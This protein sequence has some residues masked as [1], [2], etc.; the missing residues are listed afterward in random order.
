MLYIH[1]LK[2]EFRNMKPMMIICE[3]KKHCALC[4]KKAHLNSQ[5]KYIKFRRTLQYPQFTV[6]Y[7]IKIS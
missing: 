7:S 1:N 4:K 3:S 2:P 5:K 6:I